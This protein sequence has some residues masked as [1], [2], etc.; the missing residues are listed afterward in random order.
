MVETPETKT[1]ILRLVTRLNIGGP[2]IHAVLLTEGVDK[3]RFET[4]LVAGLPEDVEGDMSWLAE[5]ADV[6]I[7]YIA[8]LKREVGP[9]DF[10]AFFRILK[11][12]KM[13][14]PHILHTHMAKAGALGRAAGILAGV[15]IKI[16]TF[17][18]H[19]FEGYFSPFKTRLFILIE[20]FLGLVTDRVIV[21]SD[22]VKDEISGKLKIVPES[23]CVIIKLGFDLARFL[24]NEA[25]RGRLRGELGI[26]PDTILVGIVGR[27]VPIK[28]H[29]IFLATVHK[30]M[31]ELPG[32]EIKFL[33]IGD[34]ELRHHLEGEVK[35]LGIDNHVIFTGWI[36]DMAKVYADLDLVTLTSLNEG[37]PVSLI[38]AMASARPVVAASVGGVPDIVIDGENGL[39]T[40]SDDSEDFADK[41]V[42]ILRDGKKRE[43]MG[44]RGREFAR[45][46]FHKERLI[47]EVED[48]YEGCIKRS[49]IVK[50]SKE[51]K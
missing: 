8:E 20:K 41:V 22:S 50:I 2:A 9:K 11:L 21:V 29:K 32:M 46:N 37:T 31:D 17:H 24:D 13:I 43:E 28:N 51:S 3:H 23:K 27:L 45:K 26:A 25:L 40:R 34:G 6:K 47:E 7:E 12:I 19:I 15:P 18:G 48:L 35:K 1:K 36:K 44:L 33:V 30:I 42:Q 39:L 5:R 38:E 10:L 4:S 49:R 14:R 16:H